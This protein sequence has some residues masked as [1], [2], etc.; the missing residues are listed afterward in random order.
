M[1]N[2]NEEISRIR[3]LMYEELSSMKDKIVGITNDI[4]DQY[5][6]SLKTKVKTINPLNNYIYWFWVKNTDDLKSE[7]INKVEKGEFGTDGKTFNRKKII[8]ELNRMNGVIKTVIILELRSGNEGKLYGKDVFNKYQKC[9]NCKSDKDVLSTL[10]RV[11]G[12]INYSDF[13]N[14]LKNLP[15]MISSAE[16]QLNK[17]ENLTGKFVSGR[18]SSYGR[19][20]DNSED[21]N[22]TTG[23]FFSNSVGD[24]F[25]ITFKLYVNDDSLKDLITLDGKIVKFKGT[26]V[27]SK[28]LDVPVNYWIDG[29]FVHDINY[30]NIN[31]KIGFNEK[32]IS[33][34]KTYTK[35]YFKDKDNKKLCD[36]DKC[37]IIKILNIN[38]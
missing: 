6:E 33:E 4:F 28:V 17:I 25:I 9:N 27:E 11:Y 18:S 31:Y 34:G 12:E 5:I 15:S 26:V 10:S 29:S 24:D 3:S 16:H 22:E 23:I 2:I 37:F 20:K 7:L 13:K 36:S 14:T 21:D 38:D 30:N 1:G 35:V 8:S 32:K 19:Y